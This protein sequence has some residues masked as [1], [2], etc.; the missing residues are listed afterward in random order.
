MDRFVSLLVSGLL[1]CSILLTI[2][3]AILVDNLNDLKDQ[4]F[5][6]YT[7]HH[8]E[9]L[10]VDTIHAEDIEIFPLCDLNGDI[11]E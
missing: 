9:R 3:L 6:F 11:V 1:V 5:K 10:D 2:E 8:I 7:V 4:Q